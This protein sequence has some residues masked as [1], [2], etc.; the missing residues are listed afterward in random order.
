MKDYLFVF[1]LL[2]LFII[3][4]HGTTDTNN[5]TGVEQTIYGRVSAYSKDKTDMVIHNRTGGLKSVLQITTNLERYAGLIAVYDCSLIGRE[6]HLITNDGRTFLMLA[7][8]CAGKA[9]GGA[10]WMLDNQ[11]ACEVDY[12][13][14]QAHPDIVFTDVTLKL[15]PKN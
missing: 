13:F 12:Y 2:Y 9:D 10:S 4:G 1:G 14:W 5:Q 8:D 7:F 6:F 3:F 15:L 11:I